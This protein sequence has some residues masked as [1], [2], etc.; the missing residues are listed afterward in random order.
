M[1]MRR[2]APVAFLLIAGWASRR[3][4]VMA[5]LI[6]WSSAVGC[7]TEQAAVKPTPPPS[8]P[9]PTPTPLVAPATVRALRLRLTPPLDASDVLAR[10]LSLSLETA[11]AQAGLKLIRDPAAPVDARLELASAARSVGVAVHGATFLSIEGEGVLID[12]VQTA[13]GFHRRDQFASE[14]AQELVDAVLKSPRLAAFAASV[15]HAPCPPVPD[16]V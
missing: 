11:L 14:A 6:L 13:G 16:R 10:E 4:A 15:N 1:T 3:A 9:P 2:F 7:A 5:G 12:Q 8:T